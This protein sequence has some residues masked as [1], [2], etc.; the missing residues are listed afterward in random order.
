MKVI[1]YSLFGDPM[2]F[3]FPFYLRGL[4]FNARMNSLLYPG[5]V[6]HVQIAWNVW[7]Y[8]QELLL[9][10]QKILNLVYEVPFDRH[11]R[12]C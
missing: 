6:T 10:L 7:D 9:D 2:G 12:V 8:Y 5:W 4:Y 1:S 3:E 11:Q